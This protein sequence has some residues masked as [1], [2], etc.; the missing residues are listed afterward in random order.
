MEG[1]PQRFCC[2]ELIGR[3]PGPQKKTQPTASGR[4]GPWP[5]L[6]SDRGRSVSSRSGLGSPAFSWSAFHDQ[7]MITPSCCTHNDSSA[8]L[9]HPVRPYLHLFYHCR[10]PPSF[11]LLLIFLLL[12]TPLQ[13]LPEL[14]VTAFFASTALVCPATPSEQQR[15]APLLPLLRVPRVTA[16]TSYRV[17]GSEPLRGGA[18]KGVAWGSCSGRRQA[19]DVS[20]RSL[21]KGGGPLGVTASRRAQRT[22]YCAACGAELADVCSDAPLCV[23]TPP[24]R[25]C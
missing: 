8:A 7:A 25:S 6:R 21:G 19:G 15:T 24:L 16:V 1:R 5:G 18:A 20:G 13:L 12:A 11:Q 4:P 23:A 14:V 2:R 17:N 9:R 22:A 10:L 3:G